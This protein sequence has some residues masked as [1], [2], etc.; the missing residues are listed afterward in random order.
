MPEVEEGIIMQGVEEVKLDGAK[1]NK[2]NGLQSAFS[3]CFRLVLA[4]CGG[5]FSIFKAFA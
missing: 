1:E 4:E 2:S 3:C 5:S